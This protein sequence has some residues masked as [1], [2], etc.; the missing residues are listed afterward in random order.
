MSESRPEAVIFDFGNVICAFDV[1]RFIRAIAA[2]AGRSEADILPAMPAIGKLAAAYET[3]LVTSDEFFRRLCSITGI[4][5]DRSSFVA[6]YTGIFTPIE[7]TFALVRALKP[8]YRLGLL[9]NT[10]ELH[11]LHNIRTV[12]IFPLF[13]AVSLSYEVRA[14]KPARAIYDDMLRKL[15]LSAGRCVYIDDVE[16]NVR[17]AQQL[18]MRAL[19][20][21]GPEA[22]RTALREAG[23]G[24]W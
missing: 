17:A 5:V 15:D 6:A 22:L 14:M 16:E 3:G 24:G 13:D 23:V 9:S 12:E 2:S 11:F 7:D 8:S 18:G 4:T 10:N 19:H 21:T 20:Y 1:G